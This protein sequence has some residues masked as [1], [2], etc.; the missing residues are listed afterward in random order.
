MKHCIEVCTATVILLPHSDPPQT[1]PCRDIVVSDVEKYVQILGLIQPADQL[2][3]HTTSVVNIVR[4][5]YRSRCCQQYD[6]QNLLCGQHMLM[7]AS[8]LL[9]WQ[10]HCFLFHFEWH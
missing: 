9:Q 1:H 4:L 2:W 6:Q 7:W 3:H 10:Y 5:S 8:F